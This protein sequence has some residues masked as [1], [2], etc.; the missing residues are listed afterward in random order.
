MRHW[1][2]KRA[3]FVLIF[4]SKYLQSLARVNA[5][6]GVFLERCKTRMGVLWLPLPLLT[7]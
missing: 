5:Y 2:A 7:T 1:C 6:L 3:V 4:S